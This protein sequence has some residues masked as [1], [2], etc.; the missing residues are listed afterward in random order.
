MFVR[1]LDA[2]V[3]IHAE[4]TQHNCKCIIPWIQKRV[5]WLHASHKLMACNKTDII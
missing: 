2:I 1:P 4:N 5:L 3:A